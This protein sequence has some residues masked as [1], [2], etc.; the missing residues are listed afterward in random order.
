[1]A[2]VISLPLVDERETEIQRS[3]RIFCDL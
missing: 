1:M 3:S 2:K